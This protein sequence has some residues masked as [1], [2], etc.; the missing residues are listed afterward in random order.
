MMGFYALK[1]AAAS[2]KTFQDIIESICTDL[3]AEVNKTVPLSGVAMRVGLPQI[4]DVVPVMYA[5]IL[6]HRCIITIW[7]DELITISP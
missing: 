7:A 5:G 3:R 2:E 4:T 6:C 1:D